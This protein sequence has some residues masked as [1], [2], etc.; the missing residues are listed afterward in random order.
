MTITQ[1]VL[2]GVAVV[3]L[4]A[5]L[6]YVRSARLRHRVVRL[7]DA[8]ANRD[9][10]AHSL[11]FSAFRKEAHSAI[12]YAL[13]APVAAVMGFFGESAVTVVLSVMAIPA[14][15]SLW[16]ARLSVR[17]ISNGSKPLG[18]GTTSRRSA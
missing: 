5:S 6:V 11:A 7:I 12:V 10:E 18:L 15:V 13:L 8:D 1:S 17:E 9:V 3:C 4:A 16:W 2:T 14:L